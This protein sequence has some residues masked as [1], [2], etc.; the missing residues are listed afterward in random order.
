MAGPKYG[1]LFHKFRD[2]TVISR[3]EQYAKWT[4]PY[5][6]ADIAEVSG[7]GRVIVERDYQEIGALLLNNLAAKLVKLLFPTQFPFFKASAS[8]QFKEFAA[9]KGISELEL[10][11]MFSRME[12]AA[13]A[14]L[15]TNSGYASLILALKHLIATG[16]V[17]LYRDSESGTVTAY[18]LQ[19]FAIRR[20]GTGLMLDCVL[21][22]Y[23]TVEALPQ[24]LQ[25]DLKVHSKS[26]YSRP[27]CQV[28]KYTRIQRKTHRDGTVGY[29]VSQQVDCIDVGAPSWYPARL[30]PWMA[31]TWVLIPGEHYGRGMVE[32]YAGG[33]A[34]LSGMSE[35][36]A[37]YAVEMM[38]VVHLV[39]AGSGGDVD[40]LAQAESGE[41]VRGDPNNISA[42]EAG[43]AQKLVAADASIDK[44]I[45]RLAK[46]FMY[47]AVSRDAERVT[48]YELQRDAQEAE[49]TLGG[50]YST[51]SGGMQFPLAHILLTEVNDLA[52]QGIAIGQLWP[53]IT[54]GIPALGRAADVQNVL[55]AAQEIAAVAPIA[56]LDPRIN[57][58]KL[59]DLILSG[60]S[61]DPDTLFYS[62]EEYKLKQE[63]AAAQQTAQT[64]ALAAGTVAEQGDQ[65]AQVLQ[66]A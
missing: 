65:I 12:V 64:A 5:L 44:T 66:G 18:G 21:R 58:Q 6:M 46:A 24:N 38:R 15:F 45:A 60:R 1:A 50:A 55:M 33:F 57:P 16:N 32:D 61:V 4:L 36:E 41:W 52:L 19:Q 28:E 7:T 43:D 35:A 26:K 47:T 54:A 40:D 37:L 13:N 48:A 11:G 30:C 8:K 27:E 53:D 14:R 22:E 59:V 23:T 51:L 29:E 56:Q 34:K 17:L 20:D 49:Y 62:P 2:E 63:A 42:H 10:R 25:D 9:R 31:P 3:N 39:G